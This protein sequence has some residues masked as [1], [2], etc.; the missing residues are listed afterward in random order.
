MSDFVEKT[1]EVR[2]SQKV[3]EVV[4]MDGKVLSVPDGWDLL[5]PGDA[6]LSRR[7]KKDGPSWT[8]IEMKGRKK[9][10]R[11]IWAPADR[12]DTL[13]QALKKERED[14]AYEKK[15]EA[16][17]RRRA[18]EQ[19]AYAEDFESAVRAFLNF[20]SAH[21]E[22]EAMLAS[23]I[24]AHAVP[25]GSGTVA[26]TKRIPIEKR[27]EAAVIAWM[28]HQTTA[29]DDM[30]ILREKGARREVRRMLA[31]RSRAL[32]KRYRDGGVASGDCLLQK[33]LN[34]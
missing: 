11:G 15:L 27:A 12:I 20:T 19:T 17:R 8:M 10:S 30:V 24:A 18:K 32:L 7:I 2:P 16:G 21:S 23:V 13:E 3:R 29:Y 31:G 1:M 25:V 9:F 5:L 26:R 14:P 34:K 4:T 22:L 28:R 6:A 33:A